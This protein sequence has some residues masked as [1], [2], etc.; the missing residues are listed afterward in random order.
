LGA[1]T[2]GSPAPFL[3]KNIGLAY[4]PVEF[5]AVGTEFNVVIRKK[6]VKAKVVST[7]FYRRTS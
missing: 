1:V 5:S 6:S 7:P 3:E 4:L 2:S